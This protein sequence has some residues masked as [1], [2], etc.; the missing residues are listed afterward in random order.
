VPKCSNPPNNKFGISEILDPIR[1]FEK[2][3]P[4]KSE[5]PKP[6]LSKSAV[7]K[8]AL[9]KFP[10][11]RPVENDEND[12]KRDIAGV[13]DEKRFELNPQRE[14]FMSCVYPRLALANENSETFLPRDS[15]VEFP[16]E[17]HWPPARTLF[18]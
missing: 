10:I 3:K 1:E 6:E 2:L 7:P 13:P 17:C 18:P 9:P 14:A 12:E 5:L 4:P 11:E 16:N 8:R 15:F